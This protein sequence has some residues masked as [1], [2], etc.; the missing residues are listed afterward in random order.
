MQWNFQL[1]NIL[2][3]YFHRNK[4]KNRTEIWLH[5]ISLKRAGKYLA[6][7]LR[8]SSVCTSLG[9]SS[10]AGT[11]P[12]PVY[13][14]VQNWQRY[15]HSGSLCALRF[16]MRTPVRGLRT[17]VDNEFH[18]SD[19]TVGLGYVLY[20]QRLGHRSWRCGRDDQDSGHYSLAVCNV[21]YVNLYQ[22]FVDGCLYLPYPG[23]NGK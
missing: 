23:T 12:S 10:Q 19:H 15:A 3:P 8:Y 16:T 18:R 6:S 11:S 9:Q 20:H 21:P 2:Y 13:L 1:T 4:S 17:W 5:S 7:C 22:F 14:N